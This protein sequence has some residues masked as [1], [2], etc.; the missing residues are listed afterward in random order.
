[1]NILASA[2]NA[3]LERIIRLFEKKYK[4]NVLLDDKTALSL[5]SEEQILK[6]KE[7]VK[8]KQV[9]TVAFFCMNVSLWKYETIYEEMLR[10]EKFRPLL[11]IAPRKGL[12][13][14]RKK[15]I[16]DIIDYC[17]KNN[18]EYVPLKN[19]LFN[20]GQNLEKYN[21]DYAFFTQPYSN[22]LCKEYSF[23]KLKNALLCYVPYGFYV[24]NEKFCYDSLLIKIA[25]KNF[26]PTTECIKNS[27][28]F[29]TRT[30]NISITGYPGYDMYKKASSFVWKD[31]KRK[32]IIWA[33]HHSVEEK[34]WLHLSCFI[35]IHDYMLD[36]AKRYEDQIII[37][38]KPHPHLYSSLCRTWGKEKTDDYYTKW[39]E[40]DNGI[41]CESGNYSLFKDSDAMIHDSGSFIMEYFYT[42]NPCMYLLLNGNEHLNLN[43]SGKSAIDAHYHA[44]TK[45]DIEE[46]IQKVVIEGRDTKRAERENVFRKYVLPA[47]GK[48]ATQNIITEMEQI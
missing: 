12:W 6:N 8:S 37:A 20:I 13:Q 36:L 31:N 28:R 34:G 43:N 2:Y 32:R 46:F 40:I 10:S 35:Q 44:Y 25:W 21:I 15:C 9:K 3:I 33:P 47:N 22:L 30:D 18:Y 4:R 29:N 24:L 16:S 5:F 11:F 38:F 17:K 26:Y 41:L 48:T 42:N 1:M 23:E 19:N 39:K 45:A 14:D 7:R 27:E